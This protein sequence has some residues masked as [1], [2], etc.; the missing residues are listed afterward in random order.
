MFV[1]NPLERHKGY[2]TQLIHELTR[3]AYAQHSR[4]ITV[5][6]TDVTVKKMLSSHG[7]MQIGKQHDIPYPLQRYWME[8]ML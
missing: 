1:I 5:Y 8:K 2:G 3:F 6:A 7:F 4:R